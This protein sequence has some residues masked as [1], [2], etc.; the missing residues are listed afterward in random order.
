MNADSCDPGDGLQSLYLHGTP[1]VILG[2]G[3]STYTATPC[4]DTGLYLQGDTS[5]LVG[6]RHDFCGDDY[7][8]DH[9]AT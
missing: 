6:A 4:L 9:P 2:N 1:D 8:F 5:R 3:G 7:Y